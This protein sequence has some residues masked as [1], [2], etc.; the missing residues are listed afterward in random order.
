MKERPSFEP[1][2]DEL[3]HQA[4]S[5]DI[6]AYLMQRGEQLIPEGRSYRLA[7]NDS[8]VITGSKFIWNSRQIS[9][10]AI[11]FLKAYYDMGFREAVQ[12]LT[13]AESGAGRN[14]TLPPAPEPEPPRVFLWE[15]IALSPS[16]E[17]TIDYL[18]GR[19]ISR[20]LVDEL[21]IADRLFQEARTGNAIFPIYDGGAIVGAELVGTSPQQRFKGIKTGSKYGC[22]YNLT[23][24]EETAYALFFESAVDLL[25]F[26]EISRARGKTLEGCHLM[27]M[28]GLKQNI[29]DRT[30]NSLGEQTVPVLAVD[31]DEPGQAFV[32]RVQAVNPG[33][34][35]RRPAAGCELMLC[36]ECQHDADGNRIDTCDFRY[37]N[38]EN[39]IGTCSKKKASKAK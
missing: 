10:N 11:H 6:A 8:L 24:G 25:S 16:K 37:I 32:Q 17:R 14:I 7:A 1:I 38:G 22:G 5:A 15:D 31:N 36:D 28:M 33:A 27:S 20:R 29:I 9:G 19:G 21:I 26:I 23:Y 35:V 18:A 2:P 34:I 12:E 13:G 4:A 30:L 39:G 3:V